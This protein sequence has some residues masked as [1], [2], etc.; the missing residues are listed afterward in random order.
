MEW[1][2]PRTTKKASRC[3]GLWH[4]ECFLPMGSQSS[5]P[6]SLTLVALSGGLPK[7]LENKLAAEG[8]FELTTFGL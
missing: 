4:F 8:R 7:D 5:R 1:L 3:E 6:R 2:T